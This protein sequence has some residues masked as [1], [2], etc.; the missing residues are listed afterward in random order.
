[1]RIIRSIFIYFFAIACIYGAETEQPTPVGNFALP[2]SQRPGALYSF[3][4]NIIDPGQLIAKIQPNL[5]K[6]S[7]E[8]DVGS[9]VTLLYGS[10]EK[11]SL[12][13]SLPIIA[14]TSPSRNGRTAG[15][16]N[17]G[18]QGEYEL[19]HRTSLTDSE[20]IGFLSGFTVPS[21]TENFSSKNFS[22]FFGGTY[23]HTWQDWIIFA[24]PGILQWGGNPQ[25]RTAPR[26][27]YEAGIG[28]NLLSKS[29]QYIFAG[30]LEVNG[31]HDN[32]NRSTVPVTRNG[33]GH[34]YSDGNILFISPSLFFST[35]KWLF[36]LD[37]SLPITQTWFGTRDRVD[38]FTGASIAYTFI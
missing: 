38:Y 14:S 11:T 3:G 28:R 4:S 18:L 34:L 2:Q 1:M 6:D 7:K 12:L 9:G 10:S 33:G 20:Q 26:I 24:A 22:Y 21:G 31:Q 23:N 36:E 19:Y 27:F 13:F 30:F 35:P 32:K 16:G 29:G 15:F 8:R 5:Y 17:L 37:L 25:T